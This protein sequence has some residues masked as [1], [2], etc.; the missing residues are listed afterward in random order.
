[1]PRIESDQWTAFLIVF[2]VAFGL[3]L[4]LTPQTVKLGHRLQ[5]L[6][7]PGGRRR[8]VRATSKVGGLAIV[9]AF[10]AA[11]IVAQ[12]TPVERTDPNEIIRL[13]GLL[14][15]G[16]FIY[17]VG[18]LDDKY[19]FSPLTSY[20]AQLIAA[21]IAVG[22]LIFIQSF[23]NP[24]TGDTQ[25]G[26]PYWVTVTI[27][28]FWLGLMMNTVNFLDGLD[29]LAAGVTA[30]ASLMIFL[31]AAF[32]LNQV[33]V[34]LL[35]LALF[36]ATLGFL[37][38]NFHPARVFMGGG[39]VFLGFTL[40]CLSIIGGAKMATIL[41]VM[42]LPLM[43]LAWQAIRRLSH[44][45]NP[46]FGDRGHLHFRLADLGYSQR[47]IVLGYYAFSAVFGGLAL[48]TTSR[49]YK[50]TGLVV[51]AVILI[52]T[53]AA[54]SWRTRIAGIRAV[55]QVTDNAPSKKV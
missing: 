27:S 25:T 20:L 30:I 7:V 28:L 46:M 39:A 3:A 34:G 37:P 10:M 41:L 52:G 1:M 6:A 29:G 19:D 24:L 12:F 47:A 15:G 2:G 23:N 51:M 21:A 43:D 18:F 55:A 35:P 38:F 49:L 33:S 26:W 42:G 9:A 31:H 54:V 14:A 40:G 17:G 16:L 5:I 32:Q 11:A 8:H 13:T 53:F 45:R 44:G 4:L 22:C 36:G 50:L 48:L